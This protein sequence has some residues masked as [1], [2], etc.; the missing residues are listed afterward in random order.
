MELDTNILPTKV[1]NR[2]CKMSSNK[3]NKRVS[4]ASIAL[5]FG[6]TAVIFSTQFFQIKPNIFYAIL[7]LVVGLFGIVYGFV[8]WHQ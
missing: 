5:S 7:L 2:R 4:Q 6:L 1:N 8:R 3:E